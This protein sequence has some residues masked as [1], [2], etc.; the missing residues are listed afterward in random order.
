[1][2]NRSLGIVAGI[3]AVV[4]I[5]LLWVSMSPDTGE[6]VGSGPAQVQT[7]RAVPL[8][9]DASRAGDGLGQLANRQ[10][11]TRRVMSPRPSTGRPLDQGRGHPVD[12]RPVVPEMYSVDGKGLERAFA[13]AKPE[14]QACYE[15]ARFHTPDLAATLTLELAITPSEGP[16]GKVTH[17]ATTSEQDAPVFEGCVATVFEDMRFVAENATTVRYPI[18]FDTTGDAEAPADAA[19]N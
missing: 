1:M 15:T 18:T 4:L 17:V 2:N 9:P 5:G 12:F 6:P 14:L 13:D 19:P 16:F 10:P 8:D 7:A 3:G 11:A